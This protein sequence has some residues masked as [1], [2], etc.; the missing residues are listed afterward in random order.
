MRGLYHSVVREGGLSVICL[1]TG[2]L[3]S[4]CVKINVDC[5]DGQVNDPGAGGCYTRAVVPGDMAQGQP[6]TSGNK[7]R[8]ENQPNCNSSNPSLKCQTVNNSGACECK[9]M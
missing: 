7:C 5:Q 3:L 4:G 1:M 6:C 2:F 8:F 9:C